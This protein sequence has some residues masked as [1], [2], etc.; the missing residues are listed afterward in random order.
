MKKKIIKVNI[1][2]FYITCLKKAYFVII[3]LKNN[4]KKIMNR[5]CLFLVLIS[6]SPM[7]EGSER[8]VLPALTKKDMIGGYLKNEAWKGF[9]WS[10]FGLGVGAI[11]VNR[12]S[13]RYPDLK[14]LYYLKNK[15][16][17]KYA[18]GLLYGLPHFFNFLK[19]KKISEIIDLSAFR[20]GNNQEN[21]LAKQTYTKFYFQPNPFK[22]LVKRLMHI[23]VTDENSNQIYDQVV[24]NLTVENLVELMSYLEQNNENQDLLK[25]NNILAGVI[26][27]IRPAIERNVDLKIN[28]IFSDSLL[29]FVR[30]YHLLNF[31]EKKR[32]NEKIFEKINGDETIKKSILEMQDFTLM[33]QFLYDLDDKKLQ[34]DL[35]NQ[36]LE[37]IQ[38]GEENS[39]NKDLTRS[40]VLLTLLSVGER[41]T[42]ESE[43]YKATFKLSKKIAE[44]NIG[45]MLRGKKNIYWQSFSKLNSMIKNKEISSDGMFP[46]KILLPYLVY[47]DAISRGFL[48]FLSSI[49][50]EYLSKQK[51]YLTKFIQKIE[52]TNPGFISDVEG[53]LP[54]F[55][56][57]DLEKMWKELTE[58]A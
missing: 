13:K 5:I 3:I 38:L 42:E 21:E 50:Q 57:P 48:G 12:L 46:A 36:S 14:S 28:S 9:G 1:L 32:L 26:N 2:N 49:S 7:K 51:V 37:K 27:S 24:Q 44:K 40:L 34:L 16:A 23:E 29:D 54:S 4:N 22:I 25:N 53:E 17:R 18:T 47:N 39:V 52:T 10:T 33:Y 55:E 35:F 43:L 15:N 6:N 56:S 45:Y 8:L 58:E 30:A 11:A 20:I 41:W 31:D 19:Y